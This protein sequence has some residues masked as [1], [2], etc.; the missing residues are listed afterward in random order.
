MAQNRDSD[1][2]QDGEVKVTDNRM[3]TPE[4]DL[5]EEFRYLEDRQEPVE[6]VPPTEE[7]PPSQGASAN[8]ETSGVREPEEPRPDAASSADLG[9]TPAPSVM[10]L[11]AMLAEPATL[12]MGDAP[13]PDGRTA[14][15]YPRARYY[16]DLLD[17]LRSKSAGNLAPDESAVLDDVLYRLRLRYVQKTGG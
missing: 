6:A 10:D 7:Q 16:I 3:F 1:E 11:I 15:D 12:F 13:M 4:G 9:S 17:V 8:E 5:K 2:D 14:V